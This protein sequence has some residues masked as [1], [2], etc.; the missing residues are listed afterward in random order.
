MFH[1][2][3]TIRCI[4]DRQSDCNFTNFIRT[5]LSI[6]NSFKSIVSSYHSGHVNLLSNNSM[7]IQIVFSHV[8]YIQQFKQSIHEYKNNPVD[9]QST[10]DKIIEKYRNTTSTNW[11]CQL[12]FDQYD[13]TIFEIDKIRISGM[14]K[15][16]SRKHIKSIINFVNYINPCDHDKGG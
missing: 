2:H 9:P 12:A 7:V 14:L 11:L 10:K 5:N 6:I 8:S 16:D 1:L 13:R 3:H 4:K 15:C